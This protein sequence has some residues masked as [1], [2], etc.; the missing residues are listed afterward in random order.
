MTTPLMNTTTIIDTLNRD[1]TITSQHMVLFQDAPMLAAD[2]LH[3]LLT[4]APGPAQ[5]AIWHEAITR[6]LTGDT[7]MERTLTQSTIPWILR[8]SRQNAIMQILTHRGEAED[9]FSILAGA[10]LEA[11]RKYPLHRTE[12]VR[13]TLF[14]RLLRIVTRLK[15]AY[16]HPID[17]ED[18]TTH[19]PLTY[20]DTTT[21]RTAAT[22][23]VDRLL[24]DAVNAGTITAA[25]SDLL[26]AY[27]TDSAALAQREGCSTK[28]LECRVRRLRNRVRDGL[29]LA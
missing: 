20:T 26:I 11:I 17:T 14:Y 7:T 8:L 10:A 29:N 28:A 9:A 4:T 24:G 6:A 21:N 18:T 1:W 13:G 3:L 27:Y 5:D 19:T 12:K 16:T 2:V 25:E 15:D 23:A 22:E